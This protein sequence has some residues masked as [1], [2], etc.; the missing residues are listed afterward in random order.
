MDVVGLLCPPGW[1]VDSQ[2]SFTE[3][4]VKIVIRI[5]FLTGEL[6][7]SSGPLYPDVGLLHGQTLQV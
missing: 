7:P 1:V 2:S 3:L 5:L 4:L 6:H